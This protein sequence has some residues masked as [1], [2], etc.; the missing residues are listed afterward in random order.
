M[1]L[2]KIII[3]MLPTSKYPCYHYTFLLMPVAMLPTSFPGSPILPLPGA[4]EERGGLS[5]LTP[6]SGKMREP[7]SEVA[8][9]LLIL[10]ST[11]QSWWKG[12][13]GNELTIYSVKLN[14]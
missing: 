7:G 5:S 10:R 12:I 2:S 4:S 9:L 14:P 6:D 1:P 8:M 3:I 11:Q 13:W